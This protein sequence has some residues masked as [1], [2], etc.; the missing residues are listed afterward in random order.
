MNPTTF[1]SGLVNDSLPKYQPPSSYRFALNAVLETQ[2]GT[3]P[4]LS[5]AGGNIATNSALPAG[6]KIIGSVLTNTDETVLFLYDTSG[7]HE[8]GKFNPNTKTYTTILLAECLNFSDKYPVNGIFKMHMGC[9]PY[10]YFTDNYN[11]YRVINLNDTEQ[12][13]IGGVYYCPKLDFSRD[14]FRPCVVLTGGQSGTGILENAG[15]QLQVGVYY[16]AVRFLDKYQN[17]T[18]WTVLTRPIAIG[19]E[20]YSYTQ[21]VSTVSSYDGGSNSTD[22]DFYVPPTGKAISLQ[23]NGG[24]ELFDYYQLAVVKRTSDAGAITGVDLLQAQP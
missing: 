1:Q 23:I 5:Y 2:D 22:S 13:K 16:F 8:I 7:Q 24:G 9:D 18:K 12:Y 14:Y 10:V 6:K 11:P 19:N 4:A 3:Q 21:D 20:S 15:G 17:A